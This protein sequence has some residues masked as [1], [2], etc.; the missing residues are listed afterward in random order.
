MPRYILYHNDE[1]TEFFPIKDH[2]LPY[3]ELARLMQQHGDDESV[4]NAYL[5]VTTP[6]GLV[7]QFDSLD[8]EFEHDGDWLTEP[9]WAYSRCC[10]PG[11]LM[12]E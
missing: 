4:V 11:Q 1:G 7:A 2:V 9:E 6:D 3:A 12:A 10:D 8:V 5:L